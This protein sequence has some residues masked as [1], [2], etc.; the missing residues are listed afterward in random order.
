MADQIVLLTRGTIEQDR[1]ARRALRAAR[2]SFVGALH[3]HAADEPDATRATAGRRV[4]AGTAGP[5]VIPGATPGM[6]I[7]VRPEDIGSATRRGFAGEVWPVEYL[8]ADSLLAASVGT[9]R[10]WCARVAGRRAAAGEAVRCVA[11]RRAALFDGNSGHRIDAEST[12]RRP[13]TCASTVSG[14]YKTRRTSVVRHL[15]AGSAARRR[16][17]LAGARPCVAAAQRTSRSRSTT[18]SRSAAR[19]PRSSTALAADFEK[20]NPGI[21]VKPVY[22]G[23]YQETIVKALTAHKAARRRTSRC[24]CRPTCSRS[25]TRTRSCRSSTCKTPTTGLAQGF[26]PAFMANSQTGGKT[27]GIP[28]QRSTHRALL[29]QGALQGSRPRSRTSR[30]P[31]GTRWSSTRRSS[32]STTPPA[33]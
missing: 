32:P 3:R 11:G 33:T 12:H 22:A 27:W 17:P 31:T 23:T 6:L 26:Y 10:R 24:C 28:F 20:E 21:K 30:P 18:R 4:I 13:H 1:H 25:S 7:G 2:T 5:A 8:G 9:S 15:I 14:R 29:E 16:R 19:S